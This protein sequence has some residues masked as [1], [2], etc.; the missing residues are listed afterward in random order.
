MFKVLLKRGFL[1]LGLEAFLISPVW[2]YFLFTNGILLQVIWVIGLSLILLS[3]FQFLPARL[4]GLLGFLIILSH[5]LIPPSSSFLMSLLFNKDVFH[6][7]STLE[8]VVLYPLVPWFGVMALGYGM[9][10]IYQWEKKTRVNTLT[11]TGVSFVLIFVIFRSMNLYGDPSLFIAGEST[12][13]SLMS[14]LNLEKYPPSFLFL[15]MTLGPAL[16]MLRL[17]ED[18][19]M[20]EYNPLLLFGR[21]PLF[22][23]VFHLYLILLYTALT[24]FLVKIDQMPFGLNLFV[25]YSLWPLTL[26]VLYVLC[27]WFYKFKYN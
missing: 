5:N 26:A 24:L 17:L 11:V 4:I 20:R 16:L 10:E 23:Y 9:A 12:L 25:T 1:L 21:T 27:R 18:V 15:M 13:K 7:N 8:I 3:I 14:F 22:F 2:G 6:I 19:K